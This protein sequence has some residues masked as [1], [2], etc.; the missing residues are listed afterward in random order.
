MWLF[1]W[2]GTSLR[3]TLIV[4]SLKYCP[5]QKQSWRKGNR[6]E[7]GPDLL[8][9]LLLYYD[10]PVSRGQS[11]L[12]YPLTYSHSVFTLAIFIFVKESTTGKKAGLVYTRLQINR[13]KAHSWRITFLD[14]VMSQQLPNTTDAWWVHQVSFWISGEKNSSGELSGIMSS[15]GI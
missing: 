8:S 10:N 6:N 12:T 7:T 9:H 2:C 11:H 15:K 4:D 14:Q 13:K 3:Q 5:Q 1:W